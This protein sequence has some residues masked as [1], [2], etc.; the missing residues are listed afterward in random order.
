MFLQGPRGRSPH[1]LALA[2]DLGCEDA[3]TGTEDRARFNARLV[4]NSHLAADHCVVFHD[5]AAGQPGLGGDD[6]VTA[7]AAVVPYVDQVVELHAVANLSDA[8]GRPVDAGVGADLD[9]VA[10]FH[11]PDL[12]ELFVAIAVADKAEAVGAQD[13]ARVQYGAIAD[14]NA[15]VDGDARMQHTVRAEADARADRA[16]RADTAAFADPRSGSD[17][18]VGPDGH[19]FRNL[20]IGGDHGAGMNAGCRRHGRAEKSNDSG[21]TRPRVGYSNHG[22]ARGKIF[23][24]QQTA[25]A[26]L[27]RLGCGLP[28]TN[29]GDFARPSGF[30]RRDVVDFE[31][32]VAFPCRFQVNCNLVDPQTRPPA[33]V[34]YKLMPVD[35]SAVVAPTARVHPGARIGPQTVI[36]DYAI[37]DEDVVIGAFCRLEPYVYVKRWTTLGERNEISAGAVLGTDPLDKAFT[38]QRS[39]LR[40]GSGN[41]IR[42]HFT[43]SRGTQP[44]STT[45]IGDG[46]YIMTSGHIAHNCKVGNHCVIASCTVVA[47]YV[48]VEDQAFI[49]GGVGIH[50]YSK[51]GRLAMIGGNVRVNLD[52]PPFFLY[53][54]LYATPHGLNKVGLKRAGFSQED[55]AALKTAYQILYGSGLKLK[56]ALARI[57]SELDTEHTRHLVRFIESSQRGICR[58]RGGSNPE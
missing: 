34:S 53:A 20:D 28:V 56:D 49:S 4:A 54:G 30:Q 52:A 44:E 55:M 3:A 8:E 22:P 7:N 47:G 51:I 25:R 10:D 14:G 38:G 18:R 40:V 42:E 1:Y 21:E 37:V 36:G 26:R 13:A 2:N 6:D 31:S 43:I 57:A 15:V 32:A 33:P 19:R 50:Q 46:N 58:A 48:E 11:A 35:P 27:G 12:R 41:I 5:H 23:R 16:A 24:Y 29:E 45:E 17:T 39:Y 9:V